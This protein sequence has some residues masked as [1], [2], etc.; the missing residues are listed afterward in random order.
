MQM[1]GKVR[2]RTARDSIRNISGLAQYNFLTIL[3]ELIEEFIA[4]NHRELESLKQEAALIDNEKLHIHHHGEQFHFS[5]Y[6]N[7]TKRRFGITNEKERIYQIARREHLE[8]Q[9][10]AIEI[11]TSRLVKALDA[12]EWAR[13]ENRVI[14]KLNRYA[15][16]NL[17]LS[18]ILFTKEQNEWIDLPYSPN[19]F[20]PES[21]TC[22]TEGGIPVR[23]NSEAKIGTFFERIGLPYRTDDLVEIH[24]GNAGDRAFRN[25]YFADFKAPNLLGGITIHE[26]LGAFQIDK[27]AD[28][29]L[30]RLNDY[31]SFQVFELPYR[32]VRAEEFTWSLEA[33]IKDEVLLRRVI[34]RIL[35]P[36]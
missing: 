16:A 18:R 23:S 5:C 22:Q 33:D 30:Q 32:P 20:H 9:E 8:N 7:N 4:I 19:P 17:D 26:H 13:H 35:F 21:L 31:R 25:N 10:K 2:P 29:A 24:T 36:V 6:D 28:N 11:S 34:R 14:R 27:Y 12:T 15:Q 3:K 1:Q